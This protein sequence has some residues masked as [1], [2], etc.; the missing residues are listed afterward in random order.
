MIFPLLDIIPLPFRTDRTL[1]SV[2]YVTY[3]LLF[4]NLFV[5]MLCLGMSNYEFHLLTLQWGFIINKPSLLTLFTSLFLHD[6][7][8]HLL[9]NML[10]LWLIGTVLESGI[11]SITFLLLYFASAVTAVMI[12][13]LIGHTFFPGSL[14]VPL[15]GAS[16]AISGITG[17]AA[18]RFH[19][20]RALTV[21]LISLIWLPVPAP[22]PLL[23][24]MPMWVFALWFALREVVMGLLEISVRQNTFVAHWAHIGGLLL[25]VLAAMLLQVMQEGRREAVLEDSVRASAGVPQERTRRDAQRLL[26]ERPDDPEVLEAMAA[27]SLVNGEQERSRDLYAR[28]IPLFLSSGQ[29]EK[30][31][32]CYGNIL[33]NFPDMVLSAR[34]QMSVAAT[35]ESLR[36]YPEALQAFRLMAEH[37]PHLEEAQTAWLRAALICHRHLENPAESRRILQ[38]LQAL[39]PDSPWS[40]LVRERLL[41]LDKELS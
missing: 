13:G 31:A 4:C 27:L 35:L 22:I 38:H 6:G 18:M 10:I 30:A 9:S 23:I 34:E 15:I 28:A 20:L 11:G 32:A 5:Y 16:G 7:L 12:N 33:R 41:A 37:Y 21:P 26:H 25:G 36:H 39:H 17:F 14:A 29:R 2:P 40:G 1:R 3:T 24:W 8:L 19:R